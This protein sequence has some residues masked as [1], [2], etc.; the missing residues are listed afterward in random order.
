MANDT[1]QQP[2]TKQ[3]ITEAIG[4]L[5]Q[6]MVKWKDENLVSNKKWKDE[7]INATDEKILKS[8][9]RII[10]I[11]KR[12]FDTNIELALERQ[13]T[14]L[15]HKFNVIAENLHHNAVGANKDEIETLKDTHKTH[16]LRITRLE[17]HTNLIAA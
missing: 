9:N 17:K 15:I 1:S 6:Y 4:N 12:Y 2:A 11:L 8:E 16:D 7:I 5:H 10:R 3:D 13:E 14:S